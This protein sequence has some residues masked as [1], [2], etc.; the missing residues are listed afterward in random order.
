MATSKTQQSE[1]DSVFDWSGLSGQTLTT[2]QGA[3]FKVVRVT[4]KAVTIRPERGTR[5]Y[6]LSVPRE[7]DRCVGEYFSGQFFP[8][9]TDLLRVGVR[10]ERNCYVWGVLKAVLVD[11]VLG[12]AKPSSAQG[13]V[14][15]EAFAGD[16]RITGMAEFDVGF[17]SEGDEPAHI[18]L[19]VLAAGEIHGRYSFGYSNGSIT[20]AVREFGGSGVLLFSFEG[21]DEMDHVSG[22]GWARL[23][24]MD[25]L[26]GE[27]MR[28]YGPFAAEK[29]DKAGQMPE[30]TPVLLTLGDAD[31]LDKTKAVGKG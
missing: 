12:E 5:D 15:L 1:S 8:T 20:G 23:K 28:T 22:A 29:S 9:A 26:E 2:S 10:H 25:A 16:W 7:L 27:F 30:R 17:L 21:T 11:K 31:P 24:S 19:S 14:Q 4:A 13:N 18:E 6:E 3:R